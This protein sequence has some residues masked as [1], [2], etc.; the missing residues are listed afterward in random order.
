MIFSTQRLSLCSTWYLLSWCMFLY[1]YYRWIYLKQYIALFSSFVNVKQRNYLSVYI[2]LFFHFSFYLF[3]CI[4]HFKHLT[5]LISVV[6]V[7]SFSSVYAMKFD[8]YAA[9]IYYPADECLGHSKSFFNSLKIWMNLFV[10]SP[11][12]HLLI[13]AGKYSSKWK[14]R[15]K[16]HAHFQR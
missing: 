16:E 4:L 11:C 10:L 7:H 8:K 1:Y 5:M 3:F 15:V 12:E 13:F 2:I 9:F 6:L 14:W